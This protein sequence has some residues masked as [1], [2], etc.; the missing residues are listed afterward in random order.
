MKRF[1]ENDLK[2][3][4]EKKR[5]KPLIL[6]GARQVGKTYSVMR[7]G[8][9]FFDNVAVVNLERNPEWHHI[10]DGNLDVSGIRA[11]LEIVLKQKIVPGKTLLF[12]DEIQS[13]P[14]AITALRYFYE[15]MPNLHVV[16]A[17]SLLEFA[18]DDISFPVGR[19]QF[20]H[21]HPLCF[22]EY[23]WATGNNE[24]A[25]IILGSPEIV[26]ETIHQFLSEEL[27]RYFFIGGMPGS[28]AAYV[29]TGSMQESFEVQAEICDTYRLDFAKYKPQADKYCLNSVL[30]TAAQNVGQQ[31]K[32][33]RLA[34]G[35]SNP[36][37][38]KAFDLLCLANVIRK[39]PSVDPSG[40]PL[41]AT[42]AAKVF[43]AIMVDIGLLRYL[44]GMPV[45][46]EYGKADLNNIYRG[47]MSEQFVG[48]EMVL[49][50][51]QDVYYWSRRA[52]SSS[53]E[54]DYVAVMDGRI[55]PVEVKSGAS[56]TLKSL[57][58]FLKTYK[59]CSKAIVFSTRPYAELP[60]TKITFIPLYFAFSA[61]GGSMSL[62]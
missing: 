24:A 38:K 7:F 29:K 13:C 47:A 28:V 40:L 26:S 5:R 19:V 22:A 36:T 16:T 15:E 48:Q 17:G 44:S 49:S 54:V 55:H 20:L 23:L 61:T 21:L 12:I 53:S 27:R 59:S 50:Q 45:D 58:L 46:V 11:D 25:N 30:T 10:F 35:Y 37:L 56:G 32:Y 4:K 62:T 1:I 41:G 43:K 33:S 52:K 9:D 42:A 31:I 3:W 2:K 57:H 51:K 34:D 18:I 60:E 8:E 39:I 6:R 14:R